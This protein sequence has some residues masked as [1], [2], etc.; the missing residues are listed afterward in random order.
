MED[1]KTSVPTPP[2]V[3]E[4]LLRAT[5]S[6]EV[7]VGGQSLAFWTQRFGLA[8]PAGY[9]AISHDTDFLARRAGDKAAVQRFADVVSGRTIFPHERAMTA[10]VGMAVLDLAGDEFINVDVIHSV[11]GLSA[12]EIRKWAIQV[13]D[14]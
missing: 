6:G 12:T 11:I 1:D 10:L 13:E 2:A 3:V 5:E 8:L 14:G 4:R 9:V 7:L